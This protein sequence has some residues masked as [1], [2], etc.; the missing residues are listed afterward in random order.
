MPSV[1]P[2]RS[3][4]PGSIGAMT[5]TI[6]LPM[7]RTSKRLSGT[8]QAAPDIKWY[9]LSKNDSELWPSGTAFRALIASRTRVGQGSPVQSAVRRREQDVGSA[10][11]GASAGRLVGLAI[12]RGRRVPEPIVPVILAGGQ[13]TRLWPMS[14]SA[15]PKQFLP[16]TGEREPVPGD[17][18]ARLRS[19][20]L[21]PGAHPHQ[22]R[23]PLPRRRAGARGRRAAG[24]RAA[25][26]GRAQHRCGHRRRRGLRAAE[27]RRRRGPPRPRVRSRD[28]R[29]R[30]LLERGATPPP[31]PRAQ[32]WL[33]TFGIAPTAP[34]TGYGY[35]E[36]GARDRRARRRGEALHRKAAARRCRGHDRLGRLLVELGHVH[37]RRQHL[38]RGVPHAS[39][40]RRSPRPRSRSR[41]PRSISTSSA[42]TPMPSPRRPNISVDYAIFEK[43]KKA[44]VLPVTFGWSDLGS[45]DAVWKASPRD[46]RRQ[47]RHRPRDL[48]RHAR[49]RWSSPRRPTSRSAA[50]TTSS[51][52]PARTRSMSAG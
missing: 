45:W 48:R 10:C 47:R 20:A 17:A 43:T 15:R 11:K 28:R 26:A 34:E 8:G 31:T 9:E 38:H 24:G 30:R 39:R 44:A 2:S 6:A 46:A 12:T 27:V 40:P 21:R 52:S 16:L 50:S 51:S 1:M 25:R 29:R 5:S 33:V 3:R 13:G 14:R 36:A 41:R 32:G 49:S 22:C 19:R 7:V 23:L 18:A 4:K 35:I 37:A 42:S